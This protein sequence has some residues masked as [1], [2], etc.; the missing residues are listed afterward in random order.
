MFR[1]PHTTQAAAKGRVGR[2]WGV[3]EGDSPPL[4]QPQGLGAICN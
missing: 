4:E 2:F 3:W 1:L